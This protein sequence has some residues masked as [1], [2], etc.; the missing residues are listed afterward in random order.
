MY[1]DNSTNAERDTTLWCAVKC[2]AACAGVC[3]AD[4]PGP[5]DIVGAA[6][7]FVDFGGK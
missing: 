3:V 2:G 4:G 1:Q 6:Y 5:A 7:G